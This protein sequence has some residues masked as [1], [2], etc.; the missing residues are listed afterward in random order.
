MLKLFSN[1]SNILEQIHILKTSVL[2]QMTVQ[3]IG[4][5]ID[6]FIPLFL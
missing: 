3:A 4:I 5:P 2:A 6:I 1:V